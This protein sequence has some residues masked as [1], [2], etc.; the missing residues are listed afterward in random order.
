MHACKLANLNK[1]AVILYQNIIFTTM[2]NKLMD[3]I[4]RLM[5]LRYK[6]H[7][8]HGVDIGNEAPQILT[9][10]V[11]MVTTDTV[12]YEVDKETGYLVKEGDII[13]M[14][15]R[16][17]DLLNNL[18]LAKEMGEEGR[19]YVVQNFSLSKHIAKI[20]ELLMLSKT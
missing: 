2:S 1:K 12:K 10:F 3:P 9:C 5:G 13:N 18:E 17:I 15:S 8:W 19:E 16:I 14:A 6:S 20:S 11:E 4:G 7:P